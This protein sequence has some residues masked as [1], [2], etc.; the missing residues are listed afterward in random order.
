[1]QGETAKLIEVIDPEVKWIRVDLF[2]SDEPPCRSLTD[3]APW[4]RRQAARQSKHQIRQAI[5]AHRRAQEACDAL[6]WLCAAEELRMIVPSPTLVFREPGNISAKEIPVTAGS[7]LGRLRRAVQALYEATG[8][9]PEGLVAYVLAGDTQRLW[10]RPWSMEWDRFP[11]PLASGRVLNR[12]RLRVEFHITQLGKSEIRAFLREV[13]E[14]THEYAP[15][16]VSLTR[17]EMGLWLAVRQAGGVPRPES[18]RREWN[19]LA[20]RAGYPNGQAA[21]VAFGRLRAKLGKSSDPKD[22]NGVFAR[23]FGQPP[24]V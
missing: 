11:E 10:F 2:G 14:W 24:T 12:Q 22:P 13:R 4:L 8:L 17:R 16:P 21:R 6:G 3:V 18:S 15:N 19:L 23:L 1:M 7:V 20:A 5:E 9:D